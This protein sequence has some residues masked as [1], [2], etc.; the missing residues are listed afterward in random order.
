[1]KAIS[2]IM[3][4]CGVLGIAAA[5]GESRFH[6]SDEHVLDGVWQ[7]DLGVARSGAGL[8]GDP[9]TPVRKRRRERFGGGGVDVDLI[10]RVAD[11]ERQRAGELRSAT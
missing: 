9:L 1:M 4:W 5:G 7:R 11:V 10:R 2:P 6:H 3:P 8:V